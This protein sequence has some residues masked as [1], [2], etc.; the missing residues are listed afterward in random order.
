MLVQL[1]MKCIFHSKFWTIIICDQKILSLN[2]KSSRLQMFFKKGVLK[3]FAIFTVKRVVDLLKG[4]SSA[5]VFLQ[6]LQNF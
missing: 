1:D 2:F 4:E 6:I 3:N 5:G